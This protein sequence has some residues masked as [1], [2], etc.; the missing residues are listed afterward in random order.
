MSARVPTAG[1]VRQ[2]AVD[3]YDGDLI[4]DVA[5]I[6]APSSAEERESLVIAFGA[7]DEAPSK[8]VPVA[9]LTHTDQLLSHRSDGIGALIGASTQTIGGRSVATVAPARP[10]ATARNAGRVEVAADRAVS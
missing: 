5:Y 7:R 3:D 10:N 9:R 4:N 1:L 2:L 6:E 8:G